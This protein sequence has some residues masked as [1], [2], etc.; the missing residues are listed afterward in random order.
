MTCLEQTVLGRTAVSQHAPE[1][2]LVTSVSQRKED[3]S[4]KSNLC[5]CLHTTIT[6]RHG[7]L[8]IIVTSVTEIISM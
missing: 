2:D 8:Q 5:I 1:A 3:S 6:L 7:N 4:G